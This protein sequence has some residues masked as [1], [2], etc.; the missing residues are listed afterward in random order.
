MVRRNTV[1]VVY[2]SSNL[3][4]HPK[5]LLSSYSGYY[6]CFVINRHLFDSN[7]ELKIFIIRHGRVNENTF[8]NETDG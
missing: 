3:T 1:D 6:S 5:K 4:L 2:V 8:F 7:R